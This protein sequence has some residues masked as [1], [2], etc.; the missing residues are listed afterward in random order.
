MQY[1]RAIGVGAGLVSLALS[2]TVRADTL[3]MR[4]GR[5]VDGDLVAVRDGVIEWEGRRGFLGGRE[6]MR[7]ERD[8]VQAIEL[9]EYGR[10]NY[11][12]DDRG[13]DDRGRPSGMRER[14]VSVDSWIQWK[15]SGI[16]LRAGQ[17]IYFEASGRVRWGPNRQDGPEGERNSPHNASRPIPNRPAAGLIGRVG[18]SSDFFFIGDERGGIRVRSSGRLYLGVNDDYLKDNTGSFRVTVYY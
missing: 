3:V 5:R 7:V 1:A 15:D 8:D 18:E 4:D 12:S 17:T 9:S 10:S 16:D 14:E 6:R 2:V 13:R 11:T